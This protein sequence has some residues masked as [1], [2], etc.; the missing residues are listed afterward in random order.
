MFVIVKVVMK[1]HGFTAIEILVVAS[2]IG[3]LAIGGYFYLNSLPNDSPNSADN[4]PSITTNAPTPSE[5]PQQSELLELA[6]L[7]LKN[8][9]PDNA[10]ANTR[11]DLDI[12]MNALRDYNRELKG[13]YVFGDKLEGNRQNPNFEFASVREGAKIIA[14][15]DGIIAFIRVQPNSSDAEVFLQPKENSIWTIGYDHI[16]NIAVKQ[17]DRVQVGDIIGEA[18]VQNN[19]LRRFEIQVNKDVNGETTHICPTTL[20]S[21][22]ARTSIQNDLMEMQNS[23]E[24]ISGIHD[25]YDQDAQNPAG[26][27]FE[28]LTPEQ[29]EGR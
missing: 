11:S 20:L 28:A 1:N 7:G 23:W 13:F 14:A 15:I 8:I 12:S 3:M 26:C 22:S 4:Q 5:K 27:L 16:T 6:N 18:A 2:I 17:G 10:G 25:L 24:A 29:A 9:A 19:G 21:G